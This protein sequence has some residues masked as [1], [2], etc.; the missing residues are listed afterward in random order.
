MSDRA[1]ELACASLTLLESLILE[2]KDKGA[3]SSEEIIGV[4]E[5]A[6]DAHRNSDDKSSGDFH[7]NVAK[8]I[9]LMLKDG[10]ATNVCRDLDRLQ[11][12]LK[13]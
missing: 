4:F 11:N 9:D 10:D 2:L 13:K 12:E 3:L 7:A 8:T 5:D 1:L 6:R